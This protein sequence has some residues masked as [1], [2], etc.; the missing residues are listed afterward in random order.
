MKVTLLFRK[1]DM[2][3]DWDESISLMWDIFLM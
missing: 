3:A 1:V 2:E